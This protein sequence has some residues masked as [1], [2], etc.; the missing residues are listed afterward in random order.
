MRPRTVP[1]A[2]EILESRLAHA[3]AGF[4]KDDSEDEEETAWRD[5]FVDALTMAIALLRGTK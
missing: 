3:E 2:I 1:D 5:G 4:E